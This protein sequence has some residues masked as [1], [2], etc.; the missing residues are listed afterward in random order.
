M[1]LFFVILSF[2]S[3][4]VSSQNLSFSKGLLS[5][6][7]STVQA[8]KELWQNYFNAVL[9]DDDQKAQSYYYDV[10]KCVL[11]PSFPI[12]AMADHHT[13]SIGRIDDNTF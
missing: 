5:P 9:A 8:V 11:S 13:F 12:Y 4:T 7:D 2:L 1:K 10:V 3:L 6:S